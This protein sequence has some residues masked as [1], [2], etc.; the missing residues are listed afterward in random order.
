MLEIT[1]KGNHRPGWG[2]GREGPGS[3]SI[4]LFQV[5]DIGVAFLVWFSDI[6]GWRPRDELMRCVGCLEEF[7]REVLNCFRVSGGLQ[8]PIKN[9]KSSVH[10]TLKF[11]LV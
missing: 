1:K 5:S 6:G 8:H 3:M 11:S 2:F 10:T 9:I 4:S 7:D